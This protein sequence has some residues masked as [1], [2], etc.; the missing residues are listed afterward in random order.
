MGDFAY[1]RPNVGLTVPQY[2]MPHFDLAASTRANAAVPPGGYR[3]Y[4]RAPSAGGWS[5]GSAAGGA[6]AAWDVALPPSFGDR[7]PYLGDA[8]GGAAAS[9]SV[10]RTLRH[11]RLSRVI[12]RLA[13]PS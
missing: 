1:Y 3:R 5:T 8:Y 7:V 13:A 2:S 6:A 12:E 4:A 11:A 10:Q 9:A